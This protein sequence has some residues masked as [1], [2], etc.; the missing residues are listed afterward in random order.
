MSWVFNVLQRVVGVIV[1]FNRV[2]LIA[3]VQAAFR[4]LIF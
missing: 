3:L 1:G 2:K 4:C